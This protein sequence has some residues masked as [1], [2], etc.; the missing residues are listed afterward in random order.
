[1]KGANVLVTGG[2]GLV[3]SNIPFG[4]KPTRAAVDLLDYRSM[5]DFIDNSVSP[6][7]GFDVDS[8]VHAAGKVGGVGGNMKD[9]FAYFCENA[10]M[11][12]NVLRLIDTRLQFV[13]ATLLLSTCIFPSN[14]PYPV[15]MRDLHDGVPH[16][17]N[18]GYAHAKRMLHIGA[19]ALREKAAKEGRNLTVRTI[20]PCNLY[21]QGDN[22]DIEDG[23]VI[24]S[25]IHKAYTA[26][27]RGTDLVV[28]GSGNAER[29][30][31]I[32]SDLGAI[33]DAIHMEKVAAPADM[34][35]APKESVSI[36]RVVDIIVSSIGFK[37]KVMYDSSRPEGIMRKPTRTEDFH[38]FLDRAGIALTPIEEGIERTVHSFVKDYPHV[39][40]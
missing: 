3:G 15:S 32:A 2:G 24:P 33:L 40:I 8:I 9:Q 1:M 37:G 23:H 36:R 38:E 26:R 11:G 12:L 6:L 29:E 17:T 7:D 27:E 4:I 18:Y 5:I 34:I 31:M 21:G 10:Q 39:R 25:L 19:K 20:T 35:A 14:A 13:D 30:F 16:H 28:W 22:Y